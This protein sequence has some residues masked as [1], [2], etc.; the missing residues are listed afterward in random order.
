MPTSRPPQLGSR[1]LA[2]QAPQRPQRAFRRN[3]SDEAPAPKR[4]IH[5]VNAVGAPWL[6]ASQ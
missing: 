6:Q 4:M 2:P 5:G 3:R 1:R